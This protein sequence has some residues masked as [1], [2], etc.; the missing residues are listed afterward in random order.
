MVEGREDEAEERKRGE[1]ASFIGRARE[2]GE[3]LGRARRDLHAP[4]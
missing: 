1:E 4:A 3:V 2:Q